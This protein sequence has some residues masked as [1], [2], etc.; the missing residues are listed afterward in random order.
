VAIKVKPA[1]PTVVAVPESTP[2]VGSRLSPVGRLPA[3][4]VKE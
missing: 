1:D 4:T 2:A 3:L